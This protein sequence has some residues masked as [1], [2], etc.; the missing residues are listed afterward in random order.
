MESRKKYKVGMYGGTFAPLHLGHL[1][2]M[3]KAA[4]LCEELYIVISYRNNKKDI[5]LKVKIRWIYRLTYHIGNIKIVTLE[6]RLES[7]EEYTAQFW[8]EDCK[9]VKESIGKKIDVVFCGSDYDENSFWN[10]CYE[11]SELIIFPRNKYNSTVIRQNVYAHW[12]WMPRAVRSFF[13]KKVLIIGGESAGKT[14]LTINLANYFNTVYLEEVGRELSEL[15]GTDRF[16]MA[17]DFTRIL[18]EHKAKEMRLLD[19]AD[20]VLFEDT[21]CLITR[22]FMDFLED[23]GFEKNAKLADAIA[24]I[25]S[26]DLIL[27]L[28]P[29]VDWVQDGDRSEEIAANRYKYG[30]MIKDLYTGHGFALK[31]ISGD[32]NERFDKAVQYVN[33]MLGEIKPGD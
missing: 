9:K 21:D 16:I 12:E 15:S 30:E 5:P 13:T 11:D 4:G 17:E 7:K 25:N 28:E 29:D 31:S 32:Y 26:Y 3:I 27:Y 19:R 22:F 18:L 2:C 14:T 8:E 10:K 1:E 33:E 20:K 6:D 24:A 23:E